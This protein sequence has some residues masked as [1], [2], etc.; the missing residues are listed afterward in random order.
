MLPSEG[1]GVLVWCTVILVGCVV[2]VLFA[3]GTFI[4]GVDF[5]VWMRQLWYRRTEAQSLPEVPREDPCWRPMVGD[6]VRA[7]VYGREETRTVTAVNTRMWRDQSVITG[8][9]YT[10]PHYQYTRRLSMLAWQRWCTKYGAQVVTLSPLR[11]LSQT[12]NT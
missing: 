5:A 9:T 10:S 4:A 8:I 6:V 7:T 3:W 2:M 12:D 11:H 1:L